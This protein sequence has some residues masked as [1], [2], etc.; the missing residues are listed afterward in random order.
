MSVRFNKVMVIVD[1][2]D[3]E[4]KP[5]HNTI[6]VENPDSVELSQHTGFD[7]VDEAGK[8]TFVR[9]GEYELTMKVRKEKT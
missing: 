4:N 3:A 2:V 7:S 1:G 5:F 8:T 6:T 9:N